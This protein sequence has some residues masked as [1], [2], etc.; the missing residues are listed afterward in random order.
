MRPS[1]ILSKHRD[2]V[3]A[4][5]VRH[6]VDNVR[7]FGSIVRGEDTD[8]SDVDLLVD[9]SDKTSLMDLAGIEI[10][11]EDLTGLVF[12][13]CTPNSLSPRFRDHIVKTARKL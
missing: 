2:A 10:E 5:A 13:V 8:T 1:D 12:D 6:G 7:V 11:A 3:L 9:P 4:I